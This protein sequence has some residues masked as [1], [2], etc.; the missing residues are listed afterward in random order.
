[1]EQEPYKIASGASLSFHRLQRQLRLLQ[2]LDQT[3]ELA[4]K[5][6]VASDL[7]RLD[8]L[9]AEQQLLCVELR[10]LLGTG[11]QLPSSDPSVSS[12]ATRECK[13]LM[14]EVVETSVRARYAAQ[15]Y[16]ALLRRAQR[17]NGIL[18]RLAA[19]AAVT[20]ERPQA[21]PAGGGGS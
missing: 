3:I 14:C 5:A 2:R 8:L 19:S 17:T 20:Y 11:Q 4:Q 7:G 15:V 9:T 18:R 10:D 21:V 6:V 12:P 16:A 1:M 13:A